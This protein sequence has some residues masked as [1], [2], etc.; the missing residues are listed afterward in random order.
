[1]GSHDYPFHMAH[2]EQ[3]QE[4][5]QQPSISYGTQ[6]IKLQ[7]RLL[8][9]ICVPSER[10]CDQLFPE[11]PMPTFTMISTKDGVQ[12]WRKPSWPP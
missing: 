8:T 9:T 2:E 6:D 10:E 11:F 3:E 1:M 5:E 12:S 7:A 4:M